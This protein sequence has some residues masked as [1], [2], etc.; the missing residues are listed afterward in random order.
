MKPYICIK[1]DWVY[2]VIDV[3]LITEDEEIYLKG[4]DEE[5]WR[6]ATVYAKKIADSLNIEYV[7]DMT[8]T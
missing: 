2:K 7:G 1:N 4:F 6:E 8:D 3:F 5:E